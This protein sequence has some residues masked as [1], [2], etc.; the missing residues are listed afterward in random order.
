MRMIGERGIGGSLYKVTNIK[1]IIVCERW[2]DV[3]DYGVTRP[4]IRIIDASRPGPTMRY[5]T[6]ILIALKFLEI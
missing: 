3:S 6:V 4:Y 5:S 1:D 2:G